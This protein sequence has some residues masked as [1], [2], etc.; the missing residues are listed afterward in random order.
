MN[1][2][3]MR[4]V[5][6]AEDVSVGEKVSRLSSAVFFLLCVLPVFAT[7]VYG[8]V[9]NATWIFI[10][11]LWALIVLLWLAESWRLGGVLLNSSSLQF[12]IAGLLLIALVQLLP[13]SG[14]VVAG[15]AVDSAWSLDQYSTRL[16]L[17]RLVVYLT[18]FAACLAFINTS[19]RLKKVVV[20]IIIFGAAM[21]FLGILQ[22]L[23]N[24]DG[25]YGLRQTPAAI[26]FGPFVNQHHFAA[27]MQMTGGL[28]LGLL[29]GRDLPREKQVLLAAALVVMG[30]AVVFT[31]SRGGLLGFGSV[32]AFITLLELLSGRWSSRG[33]EP[34][35]DAGVR[36]KFV[37]MA[38]GAALFVIIF[39][40]AILLGGNDNL[41]RGI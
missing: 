2:T 34:R 30:V 17:T 4:Q 1:D 26:P 25:I 12:P 39:G 14:G 21:A 27:F 32:V 23:A 31:G 36:R 11:A 33:D 37:L 7:V 40:V 38:S 5:I 19:R 15:I 8:G 29:F 20:G 16:F 24:P 35:I 13:L 22:R 41:L 18:F 3:N 6:T 9:D 10:T 28:T